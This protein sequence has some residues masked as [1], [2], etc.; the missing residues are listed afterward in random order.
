MLEKC[1]FDTLYLTICCLVVA[2]QKANGY[3]EESI[4]YSCNF[5]GVRFLQREYLAEF[6]STPSG[7]QRTVRAH[8]RPTSCP[9]RRYARS[10]SA[11]PP[12][13]SLS[14]SSWTTAQHPRKQNNARLDSSSASSSLVGNRSAQTYLLQQG[15]D[16]LALCVGSFSPMLNERAIY[17]AIPP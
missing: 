8:V 2:L 13:P 14:P 1:G 11:S 15:L 9:C 6:P 7:V 10:H 16:P 17:I 4:E 5:L 3:N 12:R